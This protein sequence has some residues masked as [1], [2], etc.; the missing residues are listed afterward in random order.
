MYYRQLRIDFTPE[1]IIDYLRKSQSDDPTLTVD[2]ILEK[3]EKI[4]DE[5]AE[6]HLGAKV[7]ESN[8]FREV[9][10]GETLEARP[11]IQKVLRLIE[12][13]KYK[14]VKVVE[15][16]R[17]TRGDLEDI[18]RLMKIFKLTNTLVITPQKI[19]DLRDEYDFEALERELKKGNDY[20]EYVKKIFKRGKLASVSEGNYIGTFAPY[21]YD[22]I[23]VVDGK[24]KCPTLK[25]N[26]D[27]DTVRLIFD[28]YVNQNM[29]TQRICNYLDELGIKPP[30]REHW[31]PEYIRKD[32]LSNIHYIGKVRWNFKKTVRIV[33]DGI[34]RKTRPQSKVGEY[35]IYEGKHEAIVDE[36]IYNA[37]QEKKGKNPRYPAK[38][39]VANPFA[40]LLYCECGKAMSMRPYPHSK[41]RMICQNKKHCRNGSC[42]YDDF[43]ARICEVLEDCIADFEI[44]VTNNEGDSAKLHAKL[45]KSLEKRLKD[46]Q[47]KELSQWEAQTDPDPAKRMPQEIFQQLNAKLL[48]EKEE[49]QDALCKAQNSMPAPVNYEERLHTFKDALNALR[50]D[51][52]PAEEKNRLLKACI[53]RITYSRDELVRLKDEN[54]KYLKGKHGGLWNDP[55]MHIDVKLRV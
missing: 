45:V 37:A 26:A 41:P 27:A 43:A 29:G 5:W 28:L 25:P 2:E 4:L 23:V 13:P 7:P 15:P 20:L 50:D 16:Q 54:G 10:S 17:L 11:E 52:V 3:H 53:E 33:E 6:T 49:I 44:R 8:K 55:P 36:D 30:R 14:A 35:L 40:S 51:D 21:G 47:A 39:K 19:Y 46:I 24:K 22:K 31:S 34:I 48:K 42:M 9:V 32:L 38:R 1:E 12:N 18:G